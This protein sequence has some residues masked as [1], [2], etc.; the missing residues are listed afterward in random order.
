L[1][2]SLRV[3][4]A[5]NFTTFDAGILIFSPVEAEQTLWKWDKRFRGAKQK[6]SGLEPGSSC[7][8]NL[9]VDVDAALL[10]SAKLIYLVNK[11]VA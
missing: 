7:T 3:L 9:H 11:E 1:T 8:V 5:L 2:F 4:P 6:D 10:I